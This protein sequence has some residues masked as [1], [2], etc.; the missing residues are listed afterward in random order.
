MRKYTSITA[1]F[2]KTIKAIFVI[3][4]VIYHH[5]GNEAIACYGNA[6]RV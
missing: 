1:A 4:P 5:I 2:T 6:K 3:M